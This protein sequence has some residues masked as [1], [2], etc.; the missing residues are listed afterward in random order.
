VNPPV[1]AAVW[2]GPVPG[3][4]LLETTGRVSGRARRTVVGVH[5]D[6]EALW[7]I[8][9]QGRHAGYV[10]N[11]EAQPR[12]RVSLRR[13]GGWRRQILDDDDPGA[14]GSAPSG[15]PAR[16]TGALGGHVAPHRTDRSDRLVI[17]IICTVRT[18]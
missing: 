7:V 8:A 2:L 5:E 1:K 12:L 9:E 13:R 3:H 17:V 10:R 6:G 16:P 11:L 14:R 4:A 18:V 15:G